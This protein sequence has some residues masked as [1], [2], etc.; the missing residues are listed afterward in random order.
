[1]VGVGVGL[2]YI[3][4]DELG[5]E[6]WRES[7]TA[8]LLLA[9]VITQVVVVIVVVLLISTTSMTVP[10]FRAIVVGVLFANRLYRWLGTSFCRREKCIEKNATL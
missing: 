4:G 9:L 3:K 5:S 1:M 7:Y 8:L 2:K 10:S 6:S